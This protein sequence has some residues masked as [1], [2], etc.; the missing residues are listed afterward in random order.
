MF[1]RIGSISVKKENSSQTSAVQAALQA[2]E[3]NQWSEMPA[4]TSNIVTAF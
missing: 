4:L 1:F 2:A 3:A